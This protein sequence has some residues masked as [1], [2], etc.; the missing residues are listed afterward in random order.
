MFTTFWQLIINSSVKFHTSCEGT[1]NPS[2]NTL[3]AFNTD[4]FLLALGVLVCIQVSM[5]SK[6]S[7]VAFIY[8]CSENKQNVLA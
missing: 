4:M 1:E 8:L 6:Y 2:F 5:S 7:E 3:D